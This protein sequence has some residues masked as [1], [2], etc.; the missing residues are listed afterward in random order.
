MLNCTNK[1]SPILRFM[2]VIACLIVGLV[3]VLNISSVK[4]TISD[5]VIPYVQKHVDRESYEIGKVNKTFSTII[6]GNDTID[7]IVLFK[8]LPDEK[9]HYFKGHVGLTMVDRYGAARLNT[10]VV[11]LIDDNTFMQQILLNKVHYEN[12]DARVNQCLNF[13]KVG[14]QY[15]CDEFKNVGQHY[16]TFITVPI[17]DVDGYT[18]VG[19]IMIVMNGRYENTE[20][21]RVVNSIRSQL[22]E[23]QDSLRL[24][25]KEA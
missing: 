10:H 3:I 22:A 2:A 6:N 17:N 24:I 15:F 12:I 5:S 23:I 25:T 19:Y 9:T 4:S 18:V 14:T 21:E 7:T 11:S 20:I 1:K 13:Y 16:K 8:F